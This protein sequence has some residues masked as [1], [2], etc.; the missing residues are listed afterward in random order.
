MNANKLP[1][2]WETL[3]YSMKENAK[4]GFDTCYKKR[5]TME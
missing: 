1:P 4:I 2:N 5:N 3:R